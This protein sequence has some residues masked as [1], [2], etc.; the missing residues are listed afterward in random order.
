[1]SGRAWLGG[2]L[3]YCKRSGHFWDLVGRGWKLVILM[4]HVPVGLGGCKEQCLH[5]WTCV[6]AV[7]LFSRL[8]SSNVPLSIRD[9]QGMDS[10]GGECLQGD[11]FLSF[12]IL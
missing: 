7:S 12:F 10:F 4:G 6:T 9:L 11:F 2:E 1:M 3:C 8:C 5:G